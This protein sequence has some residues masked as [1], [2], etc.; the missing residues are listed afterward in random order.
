LIGRIEKGR[1]SAFSQEEREQMV[2]ELMLT[3]N[4]VTHIYELVKAYGAAPQVR[5]DRDS[6]EWRRSE[7]IAAKHAR[8]YAVSLITGRYCSG[9][10]HAPLIYSGDPRRDVPSQLRTHLAR[11]IKGRDPFVVRGWLRALTSAQEDQLFL[12]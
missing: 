11:E 3:R 9:V 12:E 10:G 6:G 5:H 4:K 8:E 2:T 1:I 7:P